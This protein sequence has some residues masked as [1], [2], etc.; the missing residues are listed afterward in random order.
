M[1]RPSLT[2]E[3]LQ[4]LAALYLSFRI[5]NK[6]ANWCY[7]IIYMFSILLYLLKYGINYLRDISNFICELHF[8]TT[9]KVGEVYIF[10][11]KVIAINFSCPCYVHKENSFIPIY[12]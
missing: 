4:K 12:L 7:K 6:A 1:P 8:V 3:T 11:T 2:Q 9:G 5:T 10:Q